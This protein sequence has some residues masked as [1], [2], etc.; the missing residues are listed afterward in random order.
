MTTETSSRSDARRSIVE[1]KF[2]PWGPNSQA[3]R[4]IAWSGSSAR[5]RSSPKSFDRPYAPSGFVASD[6]THGSR[7][8]PS[9]T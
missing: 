7:L 9:N 8:E 4:T 6:S 3:V 2:G 1:T 5:T